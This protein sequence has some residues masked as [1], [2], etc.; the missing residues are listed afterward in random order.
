[1]IDEKTYG[2][3]KWHINKMG[4]RATS[5][6]HGLT[7]ER[8]CN[9]RSHVAESAR[10]DIP[11]SKRTFGDVYN[12]RESRFTSHKLA[13]IIIFKLEEVARQSK[14]RIRKR[15]AVKEDL[16]PALADIVW[17]WQNDKDD[18]LVPASHQ[19]TI[20]QLDDEAL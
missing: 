16:M 13:S 6:I 10:Q 20:Q 18:E 5:E 7:A 12:K 2:F 3:N 15:E 4:I 19:E 1:M 17:V 8:I 14:M 11:H 9:G